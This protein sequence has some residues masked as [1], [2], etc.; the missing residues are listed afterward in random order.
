MAAID[1]NSIFLDQEL[2]WLSNILFD[3]I[4]KY[5]KNDDASPD[6]LS[7]FPPPQLADD[8]GPYCRFLSERRMCV[9]DRICLILSFVPLLKP[10]LFDCFFI[11]NSDTGRPFVE[12]GCRDNKD[13]KTLLPTLETLLFVLAGNDL[14]KRMNYAD[15]FITD[16]F[17]QDNCFDL[18]QESLSDR[19][20]DRIIRPSSELVETLLFDRPF[21]PRHTA[22]FPA[23][24]MVTQRKWA[25][26]V[27]DQHTA[28][29]VN[30]IRLWVQYGQRIRE[31]WNLADRLRPGF[32]ALFYG[33]PGCGKTF[34]ASL[35]GQVTGKEVYRI[36]LSTVV[37][38]Y[39]GETEKNLG[40]IFSMAEGK[41][42]ILFFDEA[43]ALFGK[44]TGIK[45]SHDRYANQEVS[46]LLQRVEDYPGLVVLS[47]NQK[48]N[49]D[50]AFARRFQAV[51]KFTM[52]NAAQRKQIWLSAFSEKT[53]FEE[54]VNWD[55]ISRKYELA[56]GAIMNVV[57]YASIMAMS[58]GENLIRLE[59]IL[60]GIRREFSKEGK[61]V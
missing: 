22:S 2:N 9:E 11:R 25:D 52:P 31:E 60:V 40:R 33:P 36:D 59:D 16:S 51:I 1:L 18:E 7:S 37:S 23:T 10:Q 49:I 4:E 20:T 43:D 42:W 21:V 55:E 27:L 44:R 26:L 34:T 24:K 54:Q 3:R 38:K 29:Q 35:L 17:L 39:I 13:G 15:H 48:V 14:P 58:R 30:E 46:F 45:D 57:Q 6:P 53:E 32:R 61:V 28:E 12:F 19:F 50:E 8:S 5:L 56:G 41:E 47:T